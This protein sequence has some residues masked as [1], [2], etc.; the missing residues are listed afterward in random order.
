LI[1]QYTALLGT[2]EVHLKFEDDAIREIARMSAH[3]NERTE[4]IGARRLQTVMEKLLES[5]SFDAPDMRNQKHEVSAASVREKL[6]DIT[7][8]EDLSRYIL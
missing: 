2:E 3:V 5:I 1:K 4:N 8:N 7:E 6:I